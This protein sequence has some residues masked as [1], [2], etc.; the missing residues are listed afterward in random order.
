MAREHAHHDHGS[1]HGHEHGH[2][3]A[4]A[5]RLLIALVL[6][7]TF[8][9]VEAVV[10]FFSHSLALLSDAGHM[11]TDAG[12]LLLALVAQ[13]VADRPRTEFHTFGFRRAEI[14]AALLNGIVL[15]A[16][17]VWVIVEAI[18]R[19][20]QPQAVAGGWLMATASAGLVIN[21]VAAWVLGSGTKESNANVQAA[22][23][24]VIADA[25]GSVAAMIAG[26]LVLAFGWYIADP[27]VS[28][29]ISVM[30]LWGAYRLVRGSLGVL[31]ETTPAGFDTAKIADTIRSVSGVT[32]LHDL[33]VWSISEGFP[34]VTVHVVLDGAAHGADVARRVSEQIRSVHGIEHVTVQPEAP[35]ASRLVPAERL[36]RKGD[37]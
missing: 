22:F 33:H 32:E 13:R 16:S 12:A 2:A 19:F 37:V 20:S 30:I 23:A 24:H 28:I 26:V 31:M 14:L 25:A 6:T 9:V 29:V 8:L 18:R 34:L 5:R 36:R 35:E 15:G 1:D 11:L 10:G 21:L 3:G 17:A 7:A 27:I 4:P